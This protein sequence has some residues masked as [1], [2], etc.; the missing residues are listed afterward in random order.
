[1]ATRRCVPPRSPYNSLTARQPDGGYL[2]VH[3]RDFNAHTSGQA[4]KHCADQINMNPP[5]SGPLEAPTVQ[6]TLELIETYIAGGNGS[7]VTIGDG[8]GHVSGDYNIGDTGIANLNQAFTAAFADTHLQDGG[9]VLLLAGKPT[10]ANGGYTLTTTVSVPSGISIWGEPGGVII[11]GRMTDTSMFRILTADQSKRT[12]LGYESVSQLNA[13]YSAQ[14]T[15]LWN[16]TL[17]SNLHNEAGKHMQSVPMVSVDDGAVLKMEEVTCFGNVPAAAATADLV[18]VGSNSL[19]S[20]TRSTVVD[21]EG[22]LFDG[23]SSGVLFTS[24]GGA[25]DYL[26]VKN[27]RIRYLGTSGTSENNYAIN[28]T[29]CMATISGNWFYGMN[30]GVSWGAEGCINVQTDAV[31]DDD[32][33]F[34]IINNTGGL[35]SSASVAETTN[36]INTNAN[37]NTI[38]GFNSLGNSWG[39]SNIGNFEITIGDG[40]LTYGDVTGRDALDIVLERLSLA[41]DAMLACV[42]R[43]RQGT[44][45]LTTTVIYDGQVSIIGPP[46]FTYGSGAQVL[47]NLSN[48]LTD[49]F[50]RNTTK[51]GPRLENVSF[52]VNSSGSRRDSITITNSLLNRWALIRGV[53]FGVPVIVDDIVGRSGALSY[54]TNS[55]ME[56]QGCRFVGYDNGATWSSDELATYVNTDGTNVSFTDCMWSGWGYAL[57]A[58][59]EATTT[60]YNFRMFLKNCR[61]NP[62]GSSTG[63]GYRIETLFDD[64]SIVG[65][66]QRYIWINL[67]EKGDL[68]MENCQFLGSDV[69]NSK[70]TPIDPTLVDPDSGGDIAAYIEVEARKIYI[71]GCLSEGPDQEYATVGAY[72]WSLPSFY[73]IS[74]YQTTITN[75]TF[76]GSAPLLM[77]APAGYD[78]TSNRLS[79]TTQQI[80]V[81]NNII[82]DYSRDPGWFSTCVFGVYADDAAGGYTDVSGTDDVIMPPTLIVKDNSISHKKRTTY[83]NRTDVRVFPAAFSS[84]VFEGYVLSCACALFAPNWNVVCEGNEVYSDVAD[85]G[86]YAAA[87]A[88]WSASQVGGIDYLAWPSHASVKNNTIHLRTRFAATGTRRCVNLH[89]TAN[90]ANITGNQLVYIDDSS[91][92]TAGTLGW[93]ELKIRA[94]T[95]GFPLVHIVT[96]NVFHR[97]GEIPAGA[98]GIYFD[99]GVSNSTWKG[100]FK[101]NIFTYNETSA[102][103]QDFYNIIPKGW[104]FDRVEPNYDTAPT[105]T[106]T[107]TFDWE[108]IVVREDE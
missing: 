67:D 94:D 38:K 34:N 17:I 29:R 82:Q 48:T 69:L 55:L 75:S 16:L 30:D 83:T 47:V 20:I 39:P 64:N 36:F 37:T 26:T 8:N 85:A 74:K 89:V 73:V 44:Y 62:W 72:G 18:A 99:T 51:L 52:Y 25:N 87:C 27:C 10:A 24:N 3:K 106:V 42:I 19:V 12:S 70:Y 57:H 59:E 41:G 22:C 101:D 71:D 2:A 21:I 56:F 97:V 104:I 28:T 93:M 43:M 91:S 54:D 65:Y 53:N 78:K 45:D 46:Q 35:G 50:G 13:L 61:F 81:K 40:S 77:T 31:D 96:E 23:F 80:V 4:D 49:V 58:A 66:K 76:R 68:V 100:I 11:N 95:A 63:A 5:L 108:K 14:V 60:S 98:Y 88:V 33:K 9:V 15:K 32:V 107:T 86:Y 103:L 84:G 92:Y 6:E 79:E 102:G 105:V 1:M 7:F 90:R